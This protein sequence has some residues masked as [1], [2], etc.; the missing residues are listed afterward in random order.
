M[1]PYMY[2]YVC[3]Y[4]YIYIY[5]YRSKLRTGDS[6]KDDPNMTTLAPPEYEQTQGDFGDIAG[7]HIIYTYVCVY[8]ILTYQLAPPP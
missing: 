2:I 1:Y 4:I 5:I 8:M 7:T 3:I 6:S